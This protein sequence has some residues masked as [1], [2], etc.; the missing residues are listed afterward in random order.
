M[1]D[2]PPKKADPSATIEALRKGRV[3]AGLVRYG[4]R[5]EVAQRREEGIRPRG[6]I[7]APVVQGV[8]GILASQVQIS[9]NS[10]R[11]L[12]NSEQ[13]LTKAIETRVE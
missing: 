4:S 12:A 7:P 9:A 5:E 6:E 11:M 10:E 2:Q 13:I 1:P 3:L 8:A